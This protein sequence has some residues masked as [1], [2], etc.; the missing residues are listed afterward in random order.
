[1]PIVATDIHFRL[2]GGAANS[3]QNAALGG[4]KSTTTDA[5]ASLFD[6]VTGAESAAGD[7]EYRGIYVSNEHGTLAY[8][9]PRVWVSPDTPSPDTDADLALA[10]EVFFNATAT[11]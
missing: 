5:S 8:L 7:T 9:A 11:T 10:L 6:D 4:A 1:M 3:N 2:S